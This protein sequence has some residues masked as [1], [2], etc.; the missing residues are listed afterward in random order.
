M[1][2]SLIVHSFRVD[3]RHDLLQAY[4][5]T[6]SNLTKAQATLFTTTDAPTKNDSALV[7]SQNKIDNEICE[8][9]H[10]FASL[11]L[12]KGYLAHCYLYAFLFTMLVNIRTKT[13]CVYSYM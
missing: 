10:K 1:L 7:Y 9:S 4:D 3:L 11:L 12:D 8:D 6:R 13:Y 2:F 5:R